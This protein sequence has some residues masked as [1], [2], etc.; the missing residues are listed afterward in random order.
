MM[1]MGMYGSDSWMASLM[2]F[3]TPKGIGEFGWNAMGWFNLQENENTDQTGEQ[4]LMRYNSMSIKPS[5]GLSY[6]LTELITSSITLSYQYDTLRDSDNPINAPEKDMHGITVSPGISIRH[7]T[8]D[9]YFL[10]EKQISA[11]Y[12]Y[13]FVVD[14]TDIHSVSMNA[15][16][17]HSIVPGFRFIAKSGLVFAT[18]S[19]APFY[20][21]SQMNAAVNIL[22]QQYAAVDFAGLS[23]GLEK[24]LFKFKFGTLSISTA[25]QVVYSDGDLLAYQFDHGV[26]GM[27]QMYLSRVAIPGIGLGGA[28]NVDK[29]TWQ[30]AFNIGMSF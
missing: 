17:N 16:F 26:V 29:N 19:A 22:P 12:E 7:N 24:Y 21:S 2:Y 11:K 8:W 1:I 27:L 5:F 10:N 3:R 28:Y 15:S 30:F 9:G 20:D 6:Q 25:Y 14:D 4:T 18:P 13:T 23:V